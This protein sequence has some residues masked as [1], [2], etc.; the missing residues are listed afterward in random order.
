M[1]PVPADT[2]TASLLARAQGGSDAAREQLFRRCLPLLRRMARGRLPAS[3]R[4]LAETEDLVQVTLVRALN[5][6]EAFESRGRGAFL[7]YLRQIMINAVREEIRR[8][9]PGIQHT[10]RLDR[11][12][13]A[14]D[15]VLAFA[16]GEQTLEAYER[17]LGRLAETMRDA[18][19]LRVEFEMSFPE[20]AVELGLASA[21]AARMQV[22]RG[23]RRI[24]EMMP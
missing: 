3:C 6:L 17:A 9:D 16:V 11:I 21:D 2:S 19:M 13:A 23:L 8:H 5:R 15:S 1:E 4:D 14:P 22:T 12:P 20:I 18:V 24:A 7:A 10:D